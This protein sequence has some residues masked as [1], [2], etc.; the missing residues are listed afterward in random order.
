MNIIEAVDDPQTVR[1]AIAFYSA[2]SYVFRS[3]LYKDEEQ[4]PPSERDAAL[5]APKGGG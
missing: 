5:S 2:A 1:E 3:G 4:L